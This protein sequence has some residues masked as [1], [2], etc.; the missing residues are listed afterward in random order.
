MQKF[1]YAIVLAFIIAAIVTPS[2]DMVNQTLL[3]LPMIALYLIGVGVAWM[4]AK[5]VE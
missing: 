3:A 1:K 5:K 2:P 4:F